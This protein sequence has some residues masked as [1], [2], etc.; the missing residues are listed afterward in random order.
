MDDE[1][2]RLREERRKDRLT[3]WASWARDLKVL[4]F[5]LR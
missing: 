3:P 4:G 2:E 5:I 1:R